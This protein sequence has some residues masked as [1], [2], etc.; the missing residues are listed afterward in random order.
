MGVI[1]FHSLED[2][3]VKRRFRELSTV[4]DDKRI[5]KLPEEIEK[6][7]FKLINRRSITAGTEELEENPRSKSA[8]LRG[9][10]RL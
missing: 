9:I 4:E 6:A 2:R 5:F 10:E 7:E 3:M 1:T 8:R